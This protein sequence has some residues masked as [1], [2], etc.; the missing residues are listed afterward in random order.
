MIKQEDLTVPELRKDR[1]NSQHSVAQYLDDWNKDQIVRMHQIP[2]HNYCDY[3]SGH[4]TGHIPTE[5][6]G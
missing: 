4:L 5:L 3:I 1:H 2:V 6:R